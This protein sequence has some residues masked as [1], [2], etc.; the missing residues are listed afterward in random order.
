MNKFFQSQ[1]W[2]EMRYRVLRKLG[3]KCQ[4]CGQKGSEC[5]LHVD[6]IKPRSKYPELALD[7]SNLQVLCE[8]CNMGKSNLFEDRHREPTALTEFE[9]TERHRALMALEQL[10]HLAEVAELSREQKATAERNLRRE[11]EM[12][13]MRERARKLLKAPEG[14]W[15]AK[16]LATIVELRPARAKN[17]GDDGGA[18]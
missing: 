4:A 1:E 11:V 5:V 8:D 7:E 3:F 10:E 16:V 12:F 14:E 15:S 13:D 2:R 9:Q 17:N 6:H 18:A